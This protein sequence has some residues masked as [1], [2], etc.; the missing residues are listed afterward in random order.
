LNDLQDDDVRF[1]S[2][3]SGE[4]FVIADEFTGDTLNRMWRSDAQ[5]TILNDVAVAGDAQGCAQLGAAGAAVQTSQMSIGTRDWRFRTRL[6]VPDYGTGAAMNLIAGVYSLVA[7]QAVYFQL[8]RTA[9]A[10]FA[11]EAIVGA[12]PAVNTNVAVPVASYKSLEIRK[13]GSKIEFFIDDIL[14]YTKTGYGT[15]QDAVHIS[16]W[17]TT[18]SASARVLVDYLKAVVW[19]TGA[20]GSAVVP[21]GHE[22]GGVVTMSSSGAGQGVDYADITFARP[23]PTGYKYQFFATVALN[24]DTD[25]AVSVS[26]V[27]RTETGMRLKPS[28]PIDGEISWGTR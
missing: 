23:Y 9:G 12:D 8:R 15:S 6:R 26:V 2:L 25:D 28:A 18:G 7:A 16:V 17:T 22:E 11:I 5:V 19:R 13:T 21:A 3:V 1:F 27:N 20:P 24:S 4:D 14:V 10:T